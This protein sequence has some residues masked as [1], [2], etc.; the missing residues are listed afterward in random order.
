MEDMCNLNH[1]H[2][3]AILENLQVRFEKSMPYTY[4]GSICIAVNPYKWLP[5]LYDKVGF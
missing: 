1:L 2:E 5:G 3:P 4:T